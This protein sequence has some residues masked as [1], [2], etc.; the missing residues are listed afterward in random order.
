MY[1]LHCNHSSPSVHYIYFSALSTV[2][3]G[4]PAEDVWI[5]MCRFVGWITN[6][7]HQRNHAAA[8][9]ALSFSRLTFVRGMPPSIRE[10][11]IRRSSEFEL[12]L[13]QN[14]FI[15]PLADFLSRR[16]NQGR[17]QCRLAVVPTWRNS[18]VLKNTGETMAAYKIFSRYLVRQFRIR[19][20]HELMGGRLSNKVLR[21]LR[22]TAGVYINGIQWRENSSCLYRTT[23]GTTENLR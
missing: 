22:M 1:N 4:L 10:A 15:V 16:S 21:S 20:V 7:I 11:V 13:A 5:R 8:S 17:G 3:I 19:Q 2:H 12:S 9:C 14:G 23:H 18:R 6:F